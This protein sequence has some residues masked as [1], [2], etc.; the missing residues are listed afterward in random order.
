MGDVGSGRDRGE[1]AVQKA[2][3]YALRTLTPAEGKCL[4]K[5]RK[6]NEVAKQTPWVKIH[7]HETEGKALIGSEYLNQKEGAK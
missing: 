3:E 7:G 1:R 2:A 5:R 6:Q 4:V